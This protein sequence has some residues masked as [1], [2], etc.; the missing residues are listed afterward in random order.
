MQRADGNGNPPLTPEERGQQ[1]LR[2]GYLGAV[3]HI[4]VFIPLC[5]S[6]LCTVVRFRYAI[7][8]VY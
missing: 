8:A 1:T 3:P 5:C 7:H 6:Q 2:V 4:A